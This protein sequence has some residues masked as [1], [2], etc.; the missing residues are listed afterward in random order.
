MEYEQSETLNKGKVVSVKSNVN[1][2]FL[3]N[4]KIKNPFFLLF[5][6]RFQPQAPYVSNIR[7][8]CFKHTPSMFETFP[9]RPFKGTKRTLEQQNWNQMILFYNQRHI[10]Y[11]G[12]IG[13]NL[14]AEI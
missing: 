11:K 8:E 2:L 13:I 3:Q 14:E 4:K 10:I 5:E 1:D 6:N 7:A 12:T 9:K